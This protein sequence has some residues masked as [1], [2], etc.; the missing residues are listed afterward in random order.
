[1]RGRFIVR[2]ALAGSACLLALLSV[3]RAG[4]PYMSD[5][6]EP[7]DYQH[8]EI[9]LF[10]NGTRSSGHTSGESGVDFNYGGA[11]NLQLTA[12]LPI[13]YDIPDGGGAVGGFGNVE[14]AAKYRL[15]HQADI[16]W[17]VAVF[18]RVFLPSGAA[19]VGD[20]HAS[21]L[22]PVWLQ[23]DWGRWSV[24]GGGGY[25]INRGDNSQDFGIVSWALVCQVLPDLQLGAEAVHQTPNTQG[26]P[27]STS[28]G[29]GAR[30]DLSDNY[31]LLAYAGPGLEGAD[32]YNWY[33]S[34]LFT[35]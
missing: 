10:A 11:P 8:Y 27:A 26:G 15:L 6:P 17:D 29:A 22:L 30:Y 23:K 21:L 25:V 9:Y 32:R 2:A 35:F 4:P 16:G 20:Q 18:P 12:S 33:V 1:M 14:L 5:D 13:A 24:F 19:H 31:H 7:T 28:I 3:A 34:I